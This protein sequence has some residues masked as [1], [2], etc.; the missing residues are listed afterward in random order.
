[1]Q[2]VTDVSIA[3]ITA[4][5]DLPTNRRLMAAA[6][7][8]GAALRVLSPTADPPDDVPGSA[9]LR[10]GLSDRQAAFRLAETLAGR[11]ARLLN[12]PLGCARAKDKWLTHTTLAAEGLPQVP[13]RLLEPGQNLGSVLPDEELGRFPVVAKTRFGSKGV[14]V[15]R[16]ANIG[17]L[18][19]IRAR[20]ARDGFA[21]LLQRFERPDRELRVLVLQGR[22]LTSVQRE[23]GTDDFRANWHRGGRLTPLTETPAQIAAL[24]CETTRALGLGLAGVDIFETDGR[25]QVLEVNDAPGIEGAE[26]ATGRDLA[27]PIVDALLH[28]ARG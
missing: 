27:T 26:D 21:V 2:P 19:E 15:H 14:G 25:L 22:V 13:S 28:L 3:L 20:Y 24:A 23:I 18:S 8:R 16:A 12:S 7:A 5:P 4:F 11:G 10:I 6:V 9:L 1:M 17:E